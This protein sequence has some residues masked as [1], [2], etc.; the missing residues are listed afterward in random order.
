MSM[1]LTSMKLPKKSKKELAGEVPS[2]QPDYPYGLQLSFDE[3]EIEKLGLQKIKG[4]AMVDIQAVAKVTEVVITDRGT[5]KS[6][7]R[8]NIQIQKIGVAD[9]SSF[10]NSFKEATE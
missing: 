5:D 7:Q 2:D 9:K 6:R 3:G 8:M 10:G 4:G 1:K